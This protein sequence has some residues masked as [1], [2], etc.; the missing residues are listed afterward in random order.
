MNGCTK[1]VFNIFDYKKLISSNK[2]STSIFS[3][4]ILAYTE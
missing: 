3:T 4:T 1:I 2:V